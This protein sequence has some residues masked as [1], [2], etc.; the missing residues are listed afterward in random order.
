MEVRARTI[1]AAKGG[2]IISSIFVDGQ[3]KKASIRCGNGHE[4]VPRLNNI[5]YRD[6]WCPECYGN[7]P[8]NLDTIREI[9]EARGGN[10]LSTEYKGLKT[11]IDVECAFGHQWPVTSNNLKNHGS[12]CPHCKTNVG[13]ELVRAT[14]NEAFPG[15]AFERTRAVAWMGGMELDGIEEE[16]GLAFEYQ[17]KQHTEQVKHFQHDKEDF[18][19]Q[20]ARDV[21]KEGLCDENWITLL[22]VS[23]TVKYV[24]LRASIRRELETL[25]YRI[26]PVEDSDADFYDRVR[27]SGTHQQRQY[28]HICAIIAAKGGEPVSKQYVGY[29]VPMQ[30][31]CGKG[32]IFL[33]TPEAIDQP[34]HRGPRFCPDCGGTKK[35]TN[36]ELGERVT[37]MGWTFVGVE[38]RKVG[39]KTRRY[40]SCLCPAEQHTRTLATDEYKKLGTCRP[41]RE[42]R[43]K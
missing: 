31:R 5:V 28:A 15:F 19:A 26:A 20:V 24:N 41:C 13:E 18:E 27:A 33:A 8:V 9:V 34:A 25:G 23:H 40:M 16:L 42:A 29:R 30:I 7:K 6:S 12:W 17:G 21:R 2:T 37:S 22:Q 38:S 10:L 3:H 1:I 4:W 11:K 35:K 14:L 43:G 36:E 32:H 39:N